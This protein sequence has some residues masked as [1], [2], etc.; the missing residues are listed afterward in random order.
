ME[1]FLSLG[2]NVG[3]RDALL[4][5]ACRYIQEMIGEVKAASTVLETAPWGYESHFP[6]LNQVLMVET[7]LL[8]EKLLEVTL[9]IEHKLGRERK[10][11][12]GYA[13][14]TM[15][16]DIL[17][18]GQQMIHTNRLQIPHPRMHLRRFTLIPMTELAPD[19]VHPVLEK[20]MMQLLNELS[21]S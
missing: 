21:C 14:R 4:Q 9:Q 12:G 7:L 15:D 6:Y 19:Y 5:E 8:P 2:S 18:Y 16:I 10:M 20:T 17:I 1:V 13:D 3:N 11:N